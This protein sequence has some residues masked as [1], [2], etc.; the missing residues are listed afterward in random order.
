VTDFRTIYNSRA[1]EYDRLVAYEDYQGNILQILK[2]IRPLG[3][4]EV[5]ELGAG[6]GRLTRLLAPHIGHIHFFDISAHMLA[7][8][9][10]NMTRLHLRN[11]DAAVVD[12]RHLAASSHCVDISIAGWSLGHFAGWY[13]DDWQQQIGQA[14]AEM[15]RVLRP[16]GTV[17]I[18]ETLGTGRKTPLPPTPLLKAYYQWL[19]QAHQFAASWIRTDY[20]FTSYQEAKASISFFFGSDMADQVVR[21]QS[22]IVPECTGVWWLTI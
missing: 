15:K 21:P 4:L 8:A 22:R 16:G 5:I 13:P 6:T 10:Q 14:L 12:N 1:A 3:G 9:R 17:I 19:E 20:R 18:L 2:Q 11:W 7:L